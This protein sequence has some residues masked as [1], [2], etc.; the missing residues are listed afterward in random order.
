MLFSAC[1]K[2]ET[3]VAREGELRAGGGRW[4]QTGGVLYYR[5]VVTDQDVNTNYYSEESGECYR[6]NVLEFLTGYEGNYFFGEKRCS[7]SE[8]TTQDFFWQLLPGD[9]VLE[10]N[11]V[12]DAFN[13]EDPLRATIKE[14]SGSR[15]VLQYTADEPVSGTP[16]T[17]TYRY[18][19]TYTKQ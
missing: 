10:I 8:P 6:D 5:D 18:T 2:T 13:G 12:G 4:R 17:Q 19:N 3:P 14:F 7:S 11:F 15:L 16:L 9:S 1:D